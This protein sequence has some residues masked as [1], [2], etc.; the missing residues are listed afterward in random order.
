MLEKSLVYGPEAQKRDVGPQI[1]IENDC[2]RMVIEITEVN[3]ITVD[4]KGA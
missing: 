3:E 2:T 1:H 4:R